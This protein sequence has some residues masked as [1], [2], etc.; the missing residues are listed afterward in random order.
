M[1]DRNMQISQSLKPGESESIYFFKSD[2]S[3]NYSRSVQV[4]APENNIYTINIGEAATT[5]GTG[6]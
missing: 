3:K 1:T 2:T 5:S 6:N 4:V